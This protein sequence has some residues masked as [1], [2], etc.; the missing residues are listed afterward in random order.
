MQAIQ[1]GI[2]TQNR[3][4]IVMSKKMVLYKRI[5]VLPENAS[6]NIRCSSYCLKEDGCQGD[7]KTREQHVLLSSYLKYLGFQKELEVGH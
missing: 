7:S 3:I 2:Y 1:G 6:I 4:K 5:I